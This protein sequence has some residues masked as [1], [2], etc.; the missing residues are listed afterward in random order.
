MRKLQST[1]FTYPFLDKQTPTQYGY[2]LLGETELAKQ[3]TYS[4]MA[5][6]GRIESFNTFMAGKFGAFGT[7]P[8]RAESFRY[9]LHSALFN[10]DSVS[11]SDI[12][13]VDIGGGT[14]EMLHELQAAFPELRT[15]QLV[16]EEFNGAIDSVPGLTFVPWDFTSD[17]QQPVK[18]ARC[19]NMSHILHN[20]SDLLA[21]DILRKIADA[22]GE[23]SRLLIQEFS[24]NVNYGNMLAAMICLY[25]GRVR[26]KKEWHRMAKIVG[27]EITFE[28]FP[29][30]GE[31]LIEM[32]KQGGKG[33]E[34]G[35]GQLP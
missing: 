24:K 32:R 4:I 19:Y 29:Q 15:E 3:H 10:R 25:A 34:E 6:Q 20:Q 23:H 27:L 33:D 12:A 18:G 30:V 21:L 31:G 17:T 22:M 5:A 2:A 7:F 13:M 26:S 1:N 14:G 11:Q 35:A 8:S 9:D 28:V 16:V